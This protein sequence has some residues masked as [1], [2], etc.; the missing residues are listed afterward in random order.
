MQ[1]PVRPVKCIGCSMLVGAAAAAAA[2]GLNRCT[3]VVQ[4]PLIGQSYSIH[5]VFQAVSGCESVQMRVPCGD[6]TSAHTRCHLLPL[7]NIMK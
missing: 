5:G 7:A 1:V 3:V 6:K 4:P 2:I